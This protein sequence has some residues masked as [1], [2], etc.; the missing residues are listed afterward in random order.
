MSDR[1]DFLVPW[2]KAPWRFDIDNVEKIL[3]KVLGLVRRLEGLEKR[4]AVLD[5]LFDIGFK[6]WGR[7]SRVRGAEVHVGDVETTEVP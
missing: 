1:G 2:V 7:V 6:V 3:G 5:K 4:D